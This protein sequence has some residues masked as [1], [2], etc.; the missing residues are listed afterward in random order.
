MAEVIVFV[1]LII[2]KKLIEATQQQQFNRG[3]EDIDLWFNEIENLLQTDDT[4]KDLTS[5][6]NLQ[7]KHDMIEADVVT[8]VVS[9][10]LKTVVSL[11]TTTA[12]WSIIT[13]VPIL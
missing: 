4:G 12:A 8:R 9:K 11:Q 6:K 13:M 7:K 2:G 5:V 10:G 1:V 3:A